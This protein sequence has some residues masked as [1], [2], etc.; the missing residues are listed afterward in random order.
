MTNLEYV[1]QFLNETKVFFLST[2][3]GDQPKT[4]PLN[5]HLVHDG[6]LC[7]LTGDKKEVYQQLVN[8]PKIQIIA[9]NRKTEWL[10]LEGKASLCE[11]QTIAEEYLQKSP[12]LKKHYD[13]A[14]MKLRLFQVDTA[15]V[16]KRTW[17][18]LKTFPLYEA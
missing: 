8:N 7:F 10:R 13:E 14:G 11:D 3:D 4:R 15:T 6:K 1:D 17:E 18:L 16:E 9:L 12:F 5:V 2:T